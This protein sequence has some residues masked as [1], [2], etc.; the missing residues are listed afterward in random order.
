MSKM[1]PYIWF[2]EEGK[3]LHQY[4]LCELE[5]ITWDVAACCGS[6]PSAH[7]AELFQLP[8]AT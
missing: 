8:V 3:D 7:I 6:S 4:T 5:E 1:C 2:G